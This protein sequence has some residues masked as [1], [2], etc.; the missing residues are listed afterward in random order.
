MADKSDVIQDYLNSLN[1]AMAIHARKAVEGLEFDRTELAEIVDITNRDKG[2]YQVFNGSTRYF[3]YSENTSYTLG[4]KVYV[5]IQNN[6]YTQQKLIKGKYKSGDGDTGISWVSPLG[7]YSAQ[8]DNLIEDEAYKNLNSD[9]FSN[10]STGLE[11][12]PVNKD[13]ENGTGD[14]LLANYNKNLQ[15]FSYEPE[16][17]DFHYASEYKVLYLSKYMDESDDK[18]NKNF[19]YMGLS[20]E[21]KTGLSAFYP[22]SGSYGLLILVDYS[23]K[24]S[25]EQPREHK[26]KVCKLDTTSMIGSV[27]NFNTFYKQEALFKLEDIQS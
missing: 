23:I 2:E 5:T 18:Y 1:E 3:A 25:D 16:P 21:F 10:S 22:V 6:D 7:N 17:D 14:S 8:T 19:A 9:T 13:Y 27:Y 24:I 11:N 20:A 15:E 12:I 26:L 4:A